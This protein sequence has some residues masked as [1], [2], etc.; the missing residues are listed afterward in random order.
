MAEK[1]MSGGVGSGDVLAYGNVMGNGVL[2][3]ADA[4]EEGSAVGGEVCG[5]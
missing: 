2:E 3:G 1:T 4:R 5:A